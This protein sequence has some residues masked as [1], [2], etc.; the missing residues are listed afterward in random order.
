MK[1]TLFLV[2]PYPDLAKDLFTLSLVTKKFIARGGVSNPNFI[3][4][5]YLKA[6]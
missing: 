3:T 5:R 1:V 6:R 2:Q 4:F